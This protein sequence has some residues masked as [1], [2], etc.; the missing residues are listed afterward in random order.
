MMMDHKENSTPQ[1]SLP[2]PL[3]HWRGFVLG[4]MLFAAVAALTVSCAAPQ[5]QEDETL[6]LTYLD[7]HSGNL[8]DFQ[9]EVV[10][11]NFWA[12]WCVPCRAEMPE[13]Q[14]FYDDYQDEVNFIAVNVGETP[15][16]AQGFIDE[17][18]LSFPVV[19]DRDATLADH[20]LLRGQPTTI[21]LN[22][23]GE[24]AY[25]HTGV[26]TQALLVEQV[27]AALEG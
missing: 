22:P 1:I 5:T 17:L 24:V 20:F 3:S 4:M 2:G 6:A 15:E 8:A 18:G 26:I 23:A 7:G 12:T 27:M 9:G 10:V 14:A 11:L 25:Q 21:V 13:L 16:Q 19:L